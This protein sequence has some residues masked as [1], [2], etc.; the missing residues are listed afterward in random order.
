MK[1]LNLDTV[2]D[3]LDSENVGVVSFEN[4]QLQIHLNYGCTCKIT[5]DKKGDSL[6]PCSKHKQW[7]N[8]KRDMKTLHTTTH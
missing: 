5:Q 2:F 1:I 4:A 8:D 6:F 7:A 3:F